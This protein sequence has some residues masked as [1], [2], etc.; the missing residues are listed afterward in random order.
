[1]ARS[2]PTVS[3]A[4]TIFKGFLVL[5]GSKLWKNVSDLQTA[6]TRSD[7]PSRLIS[8]PPFRFRS[9]EFWAFDILYILAGLLPDPYVVVSALSVA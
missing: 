2:P 7:W 8:V 3:A 9:L 4:S 1:M 6:R 5:P